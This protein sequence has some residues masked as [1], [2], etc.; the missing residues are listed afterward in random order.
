MAPGQ[1]YVLLDAEPGETL[2]GS[3]QL[4]TR[5]DAQFDVFTNGRALAVDLEGETELQSRFNAMSY[6]EDIK[7]GYY[8]NAR[9]PNFALPLRGSFSVGYEH[10]SC[11]G[12][13]WFAIDDLQ[14]VNG[15]VTSLRLRAEY[16]CNGGPA[17]HI[18]V[19]W[20]TADRTGPPGP[21]PI[22]AD[23]WDTQPAGT[24]AS[25]SYVA[26][27]SVD[28]DPVTNGRDYLFTGPANPFVLRDYG[29]GTQLIVSNS[30]GWTGFFQPPYNLNG[31]QPGY[32]AN[33]DTSYFGNPT[34]PRLEWTDGTT[35]CHEV[36]GWM[37]V[38]RI[39][40]VAGAITALILRFEQSCDGGPAIRGKV[41][42]VPPGQPGVPLPKGPPFG[43]LD[44]VLGSV[45]QI[46]ISGWAI[47]P[48]TS[49]SIPVHVY[50][51]GVG[52][53]VTAAGERGDVGRAY[54]GYGTA[55]GFTLVADVPR[56]SP[57]RLRLRHQHRRGHQHSP[58]V[59]RGCGPL[60]ITLR[61][62]RPCPPNSWPGLRRRLGHRPRH[63]Q[64]ERRPRLRRRQ[65]RRHLRQRGTTRRRQRLPD[66]RANARLHRSDLRQPRPSHRL[67]LRHQHRRRSQQPP[68]MPRHHRAL[69]AAVRQPRCGDPVTRPGLRR[70]L[71]H[72]P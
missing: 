71:G 45:G 37:A 55:H 70:R 22:P 63:P 30:S 27:D 24:D 13:G 53:A 57:H 49:V 26:I 39:E 66:V 4:F 54:P 68:R 23:L 47:D 40:R 42:I 36:T 60:R 9:W 44:V 6:L 58:R 16:R 34:R 21:S 3:T 61:K 52:R 12:E 35:V 10:L 29:N 8:G 51:D 43:S 28:G 19:V 64:L 33:A 38:D 41:H 31:L 69:R 17:L 72:R 56:R 46:S 59:Q 15:L 11:E 25:T 2:V 32:Y 48:D 5:A 65:G 18:K 1:S 7:P 14:R 50:V 20:S 67:R 62:P